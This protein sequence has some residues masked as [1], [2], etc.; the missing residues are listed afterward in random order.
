MKDQRGFI[1]H[2]LGGWQLSGIFYAYAGLPLTITTSGLDPGGQGY[3]IATSTASGRP[4]RVGN[5]IGPQSISFQSG[6]WLEPAAFAPVC[7]TSGQTATQ[8]CANPRPG[9]SGRG[10]AR[11]PGFW[12]LDFSVF[13]NIRITERVNFQFRTETFNLFNHTNPNG[14]NTTQTSTTFGRITSY[15]D[16]REMQFGF[17]LSF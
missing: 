1:G 3:N 14:V 9:T 17:K 4:D 11:G 7:P 6:T 13:K 8:F 15:R 16:P 12:R 5:P 10:V 2:L